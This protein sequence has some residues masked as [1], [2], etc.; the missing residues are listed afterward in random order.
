MEICF[1]EEDTSL[2]N[3]E[4]ILQEIEDNQEIHLSPNR[5]M[6][7]MAFFNLVCPIIKKPI[8]S[9]EIKFLGM[10]RYPLNFKVNIE[11]KED[12]EIYLLTDDHLGKIA[13]IIIKNGGSLEE[14]IKLKQIYTIGGKLIQAVSK[15]RK[16]ELQHKAFLYTE[17]SLTFTNIPSTINDYFFYELPK[18]I[19]KNT[20]INIGYK[21]SNGEITSQGIAKVRPTKKEI[22]K[23]LTEMIR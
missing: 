3:I 5:I 13:E 16:E 19:N 15:E 21:N 9:A 10:R 2:K 11:H 7:G 17:Q 23:K 20:E 4:R 18:E 1:N 6:P 12:K 22:F 8:S 14:S